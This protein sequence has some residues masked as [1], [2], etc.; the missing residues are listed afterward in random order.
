MA[1]NSRK[2]TRSLEEIAGLHKAWPRDSRPAALTASV[3]CR[4]PFFPY[5]KAM[6]STS[7]CG[8]SSD[9]VQHY[10]LPRTLK[11]QFRTV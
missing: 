1:D 11:L 9:A 3:F 6:S 4:L 8:G 7:N 2:E 5:E 10:L